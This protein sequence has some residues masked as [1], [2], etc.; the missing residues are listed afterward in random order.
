MIEQDN[1]VDETG[2]PVLQDCG[3]ETG[4]ASHDSRCGSCGK[5]LGYKRLVG[6]FRGVPIV[7]SCPYCGAWTAEFM[8]SA[9][10]IEIVR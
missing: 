4:Q 10:T 6:T 1:N 3:C 5:Q 8:P 9:P 7:C 2:M